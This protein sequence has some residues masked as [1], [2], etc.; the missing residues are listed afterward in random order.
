MFPYGNQNG[1]R[2]IYRANQWTMHRVKLNETFMMFSKPEKEINVSRSF[3]LLCISF[4]NF[5]WQ[6]AGKT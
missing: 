6:F 5:L 2:T 4:F 1:D 3:L